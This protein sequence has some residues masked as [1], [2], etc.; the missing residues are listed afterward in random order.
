MKK[1]LSKQKRERKLQQIMA[2]V[3]ATIN[4][5]ID[6]P[7]NSLIIDNDDFKEFFTTKRLELI[8][9]IRKEKPPSIVVMAKM[10][11]RTKQAVDRDIKILERLD[12]INLEKNGRTKTPKIKTPFLIMDLTG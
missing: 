2:L 11:G 12:I 6:L 3:D 7:N 9:L 1:G 10:T 8:D 5:T 4:E